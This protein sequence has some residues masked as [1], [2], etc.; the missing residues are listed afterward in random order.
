MIG[1]GDTMKKCM[2]DFLYIQEKMRAAI[3]LNSYRLDKLIVM[4]SQSV[5]ELEFFYVKNKKQKKEAYTLAI[6]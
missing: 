4:F 1:L 6:E 5:K 3:S 2:K